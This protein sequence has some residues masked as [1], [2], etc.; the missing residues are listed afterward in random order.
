M[1]RV[2]QIIEKIKMDPMSITDRHRKGWPPAPF[3]ILASENGRF[4]VINR[5]N[6]ENL[7]GELFGHKRGALPAL[8]G[9][10]GKI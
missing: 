10:E 7:L 9:P 2:Y 4:V 8:P 3:I 1:Q 6:P 5:A